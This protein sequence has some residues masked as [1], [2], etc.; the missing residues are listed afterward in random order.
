MKI[1]KF[2]ILA[3]I[4]NTM[5]NKQNKPNKDTTS[6]LHRDLMIFLEE[7]FAQI[8]ENITFKKDSESK[9]VF[10]GI[11]EEFNIINDK[12]PF[13]TKFKEP[14]DYLRIFSFYFSW[15]NQSKCCF[16]YL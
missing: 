6:F 15:K 4:F 7:R 14:V 9:A 3:R 1:K 16:Y 8:P 2:R 11:S 5:G 13:E 12:L 10:K